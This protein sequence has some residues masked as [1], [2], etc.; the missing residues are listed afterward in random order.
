VTIGLFHSDKPGPRPTQL[1]F[2]AYHCFSTEV[3][4]PVLESDHSPFIYCQG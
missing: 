4:W 3:N 2:I 1:L